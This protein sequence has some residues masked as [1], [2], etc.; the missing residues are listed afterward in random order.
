MFLNVD[1]SKQDSI[2]D[3]SSLISSESYIKG[4]RVSHA[5]TKLGN[6]TICINRFLHLRAI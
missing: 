1:V 5:N 3:N 2:Y 6:L 4:A